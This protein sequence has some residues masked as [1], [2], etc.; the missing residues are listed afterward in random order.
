MKAQSGGGM[1]GIAL[2]PPSLA[3]GFTRVFTLTGTGE[4]F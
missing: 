2:A 3:P 1:K 4:P